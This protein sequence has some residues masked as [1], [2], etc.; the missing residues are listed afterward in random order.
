MNIS[1]IYGST[2]GNTER[3]AD[4]LKDQLTDH[5]VNIVNVADVKDD[6]YSN[7]ELVLLGSSTWGYGE[8]QDDFAIH[9]DTLSNAQLAGKKVAV[10]GCGDED[11]FADVF[12][13]AVNLISDKAEDC[14]ATIVAEGLKVNGNPDDNT[15]AIVAFAQSL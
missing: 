8:L 5:D 11:G 9:Y 14:G 4:M 13:E 12:C 6:D 15:D 1:I 10:F 3:V 2:T 7:A